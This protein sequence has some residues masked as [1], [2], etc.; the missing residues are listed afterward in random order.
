MLVVPSCP[1]LPDGIRRS[2]FFE[3]HWFFSFAMGLAALTILGRSTNSRQRTV[4]IPFPAFHTL[5]P[6]PQQPKWRMINCAIQVRWDIAP[7][8]FQGQ[9]AQQGRHVAPALSGTAC[10]D[11]PRKN[12]H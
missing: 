6:P 2:C 10:P 9:R 5:V 8:P 3:I 7:A 12:I 1:L 11:S 4:S